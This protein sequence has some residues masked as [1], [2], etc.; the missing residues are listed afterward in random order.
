MHASAGLKNLLK[1]K[2]PDI[3]PGSFGF[4]IRRG[5]NISGICDSGSKQNE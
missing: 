3:V 1:P 2:E 4:S 5:G